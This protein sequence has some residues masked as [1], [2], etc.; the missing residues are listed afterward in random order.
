MTVSPC[1][2]PRKTITGKR[3]LKGPPSVLVEGNQGGGGALNDCL[4]QARPEGG[5]ASR[6]GSAHREAQTLKTPGFLCLGTY[7]GGQGPPQRALRSRAWDCFSRQSFP[8]LSKAWLFILLSF[9]LHIK[10]LGEKSQAG[11]Q[12]NPLPA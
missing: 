1:Q 9:H 11:Y 12:E 3:P 10:I 5:A 4:T 7:T 8:A 6:R 2:S